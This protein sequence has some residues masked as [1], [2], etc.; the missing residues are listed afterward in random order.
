MWA[1]F[2]SLSV[3]PWILFAQM[4]WDMG[5]VPVIT[6]AQPMAEVN[7]GV[8]D[9]GGVFGRATTGATHDK[10]RDPLPGP[11]PDTRA[12]HTR[13]CIR[14]SENPYLVRRWVNTTKV[15]EKVWPIARCACAGPRLY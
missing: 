8:R 12:G 7:P 11:R 1:S 15:L 6:A 9:R 5:A 3:V 14:I 4:S 2:G 13:S 10:D